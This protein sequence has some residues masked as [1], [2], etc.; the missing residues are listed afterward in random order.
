[1]DQET[2]AGAKLIHQELVEDIE[3]RI[4]AILMRMASAF[5]FPLHQAISDY[6]TFHHLSKP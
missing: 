2:K 3:V 1:M 4:D 6:A 5:Q